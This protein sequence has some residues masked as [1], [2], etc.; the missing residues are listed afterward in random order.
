MSEKQAAKDASLKNSDS[1]RQINDLNQMIL[2]LQRRAEMKRITEK[3]NSNQSSLTKEF[4]EG[5]KIV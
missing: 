5:V 4:F 3:G 2:N 1:Q